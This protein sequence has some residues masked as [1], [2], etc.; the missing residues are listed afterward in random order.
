MSEY[1]KDKLYCPLFMMSPVFET[2]KGCE[3]RKEM[4]AWWVEDK[5]KCAIAVGGERSR[6][7]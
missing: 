1:E 2:M 3:C 6:G 4:C 7:K 5:Q